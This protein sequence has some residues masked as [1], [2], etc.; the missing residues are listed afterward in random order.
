[1]GSVDHSGNAIWKSTEGQR[2]AKKKRG[3]CPKIGGTTADPSGVTVIEANTIKSR[4]CTE[5]SS[6]VAG[7]KSCQDLILTGSGKLISSFGHLN[8]NPGRSCCSAVLLLVYQPASYKLLRLL[9]QI[10]VHPW[11]PSSESNPKILSRRCSD[12]PGSPAHRQTCPSTLG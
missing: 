12:S 10:Y 3:F 7:L 4:Y 1:M 2:T 9:D 11:F 6:T 5:G 8:K